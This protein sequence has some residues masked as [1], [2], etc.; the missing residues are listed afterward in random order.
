MLQLHRVD[1]GFANR[2]ADLWATTFEQAYAGVHSGENIRAYCAA[3]YTVEAAETHLSDP[4][5]SCTVAF[6]DHTACGFYLIKHHDCPVPLNGGESELKQIYL[7]AGAY[8]T[9]VGDRLLDDAIQCARD[10]GR[11]WIWL[12]V[13]DLNHRARSFYGK[14]AFEPVGAGPIFE[15]GSDRL[16]STIMARRVQSPMKSN[17][18]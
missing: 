2:L 1:A 4:R 16:T 11:T 12:S 3:N 18:C 8:G 17:V 14:R 6:R 5:V 7:L 15:V 10:A 13:S 9:G